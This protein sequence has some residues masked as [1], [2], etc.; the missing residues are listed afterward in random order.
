MMYAN[1]AK[2]APISRF[3]KGPGHPLII[4]SFIDILI[5]DQRKPLPETPEAPE[6]QKTPEPLLERPRGP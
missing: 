4:F 5:P 2:K 3:K 6:M 1:T